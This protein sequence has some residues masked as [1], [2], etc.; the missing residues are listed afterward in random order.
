M[1]TGKT[2][3]QLP[4]DL[5]GSRSKNR[6]RAELFWGISKML[7]LMEG[8][9]DFVV[10]FDYVCDIEVHYEDGF[11]FYQI[12][13]HSGRTLFNTS[14]SL[15]SKRS[16]SAKG[17]IL[18]KLYV[19]K[20][21][22]ANVF[23]LAVVSNVPLKVAKD[24][25][26]IDEF[27]FASLSVKNKGELETALKK[28]LNITNV[29]FSNVY[30]VHTI[31]D[32]KNPEDAIN[33]KIDRCFERIKKSEPVNSNALHRLIID[34]VKDRA[35]FEFPADEYSHVIEKKGITREEFDRMLDAHE[36]N[37]RTGIPQTTTYISKMEDLSRQMV[38]RRALS[39][40]VELMPTSKPLKAIERE[41]LRYLSN[42]G[43]LGVLEDVVRES[44]QQFDL[45]F[46]IEYS[47]PEKEVFMMIII[48]KFVQGG[49]DNAN[50][51]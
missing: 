7:D 37:E 30:Y 46:P 21:K 35:C 27:S 4:H 38:Y 28:E 26:D 24:V 2:Y 3:L 1:D 39:K 17:S 41:M 44:M 20:T 42:R 33:G 34:T 10:V 22:E 16:A 19:L 5:S 12:K 48:Y 9:K 40:M 6:F 43:N 13:T 25:I 8:E 47:M 45:K 29:D 18:G 14:D 23:K 31:M 15:V 51:I 11:E 49:C 50:A 36:D 32:L